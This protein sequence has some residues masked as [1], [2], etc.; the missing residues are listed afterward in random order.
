VVSAVARASTMAIPTIASD[1]SRII[2]RRR[3]LRPEL[4]E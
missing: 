1:I 2:K 4:L 3:R